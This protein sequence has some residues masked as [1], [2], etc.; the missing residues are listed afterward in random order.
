[1][2]RFLGPLIVIAV[3]AGIFLFVANDLLSGGFADEFDE[4]SD[5][6][7][8][9]VLTVLDDDEGFSDVQVFDVLADA[10]LE[11][12]AEGLAA[13]AWQLWVR[14][15]GEENVAQLVTQY[16]AGEAPQSSALAYVFQDPGIRQF[17]LAVNLS[18]AD[19]EAQLVST[20]VHEW[21][22]VL[23]LEVEQFD[24][25][26]LEGDVADCA[27]LVLTQGCLTDESYLWQ[28]YDEFWAGYSKHPDV[29]NDSPVLAEDFF[30]T[31]SA[32]FVSEYAATNPLED[33]A[34]S[35]T[36]FVVANDDDPF[37][38]LGDTAALKVEFFEQYPEL[39][40]WREHVREVA[41]VELGLR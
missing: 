13:E 4:L 32:D 12:Q 37:A 20:L 24:E 1:M 29:H 35:V 36:V 28:F 9:D 15:A 3:I 18:A 7:T 11:P 34:E 10:S 31:H 5:R 16:R 40:D 33:F 23:S 39:V 2:R 38:D 21:S 17:T 14:L 41:A 26:S 30:T 8:D 27:T 6:T 22:H 25:S 19:D